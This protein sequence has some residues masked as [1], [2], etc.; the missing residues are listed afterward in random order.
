MKK[1]FA[2]ILAAVMLAAALPASLA[3]P[4]PDETAAPVFSD[5]SG[6]WAEDVIIKY[7]ETGAINGYPDGTFRPDGLVTRAESAKIIVGVLESAGMEL[8]PLNAESAKKR[9][10]SKTHNGAACEDIDPDAWYLPYVAKAESYFP[11]WLPSD[12]GALNHLG[13]YNEVSKID[14]DQLFL[15]DAYLPRCHLA[16]IL[17]ELKFY[18]YDLDDSIEHATAPTGYLQEVYKDSTLLE[19]IASPHPEQLTIGNNWTRMRSYIWLAYKYDIMVGN[20]DGYFYPYNGVSRAELLTALDNML[21]SAEAV[22]QL[23][24]MDI[25]TASPMMKEAILEARSS[26]IHGGRPWT[27]DGAVSV[28][29]FKDGT[30]EKLPEF[31]ELFPGWDVPSAEIVTPDWTASLPQSADIDYSISETFSLADNRVNS[32]KLTTFT[33][34]GSPVYV[35]ADTTPVTG[36]SFNLGFSNAS[37]GKEIGWIPSL[38]ENQG[39]AI[40]TKNAL[41]YDIRGSVPRTDYEGIYRI[42]VSST[43]HPDKDFLEP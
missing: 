15:P 3:E 38:N 35:Y 31:S 20:P 18:L 33:G 25:E 17:V 34:S 7:S 8:E 41:H 4:G 12:A 32:K 11:M 14:N 26:I 28:I 23:A 19:Y 13:A 24:Y 21:N 39:A 27:V 29:S 10:W 1:F 16:E 30:A 2:F 42:H 40:D 22:E 43:E 37:S 9:G 5:I 36:A 6:H